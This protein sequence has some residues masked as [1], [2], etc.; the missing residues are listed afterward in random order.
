MGESSP[1]VTLPIDTH[2]DSGGCA[3]CTG[4]SKKKPLLND[5]AQSPISSGGLSLTFEQWSAWFDEAIALPETLE[6]K[7]RGLSRQAS[8]VFNTAMLQAVGADDKA[9]EFTTHGAAADASS[10]SAGAGVGPTP[11][12]Q[13]GTGTANSRKDDSEE[14]GYDDEF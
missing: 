2:S 11:V 1:P 4:S 14:E 6:K 10:V 7:R 12:L 3:C 8:T 13:P 9:G 5:P